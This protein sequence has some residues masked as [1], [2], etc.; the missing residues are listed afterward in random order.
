METQQECLMPVDSEGNLL[1]R[2]DDAPT[3][4]N[5]TNTNDTLRENNPSRRGD[6]GIED[7]DTNYELMDGMPV[8]PKDEDKSP[9]VFGGTITLS[10]PSATV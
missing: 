1:C 7:S 10:P 2:C 3:P 4:A 5:M 6:C 9:S 8:E